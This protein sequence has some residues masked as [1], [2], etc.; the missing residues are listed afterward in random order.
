MGECR[1][2][3]VSRGGEFELPLRARRGAGI[4][5]GENR[6]AEREAPVSGASLALPGRQRRSE[7][8]L[9]TA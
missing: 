6:M 5:G 8:L 3:Q 4:D 2:L 7:A 1:H 9:P